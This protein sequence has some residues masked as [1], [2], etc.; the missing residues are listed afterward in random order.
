MLF[1]EKE[2]EMINYVITISA[3]FGRVDSVECFADKSKAEEFV[4]NWANQNRPD[5]D[6]DTDAHFNS[7]SEAL[8]WFKNNSE[9]VDYIIQLFESDMELTVRE[10]LAEIN[11]IVTAKLDTPEETVGLVLFEHTAYEEKKRLKKFNGVD[12]GDD[13]YYID[14]EAYLED[15]DNGTDKPLED[16]VKQCANLGIT[17][18]NVY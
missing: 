11:G 10:H 6:A 15:K 4:L 14:T 7:A 2:N 3:V 1:F 9:N 12:V 17:M 5:C 13:N 18:I 8:E 16:L